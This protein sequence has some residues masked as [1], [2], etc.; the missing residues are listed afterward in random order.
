MS[1]H[2]DYISPKIFHKSTCEISYECT[3]ESKNCY[4]AN[5]KILPFFCK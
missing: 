4:F 1:N 2:I 5:D 3:I